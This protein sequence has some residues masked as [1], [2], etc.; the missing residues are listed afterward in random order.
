MTLKSTIYKLSLLSGLIATAAQ[1]NQHF[2]IQLNANNFSVQNKNVLSSSFLKFKSV[3]TDLDRTLGAPELPVKTWLVSGKPE[4]IKVQLKTH[5]QLNYQG[6]PY[7]VQP[8]D[9]RC[10]IPSK[11]AQ[12]FQFKNELYEKQQNTV[13]VHYL[14]AFRGQ[15]ISQVVVRLGK[16]NSATQET[17]I[18]TSAEVT[19]NTHEFQM[20][21][22][23]YKNFLI[24]T[25]AQLTEGLN[26]FI[27]WKTSQGYNVAVETVSSPNNTTTAIQALIKKYYTDKKADFVMIVGDENTIPMFKVSTSGSSQTPSD[28]KYFTMDGAQDNVPDIFASRLVADSPA[29][30]TAQL[31]K[32]IEFEKL[33][34]ENLAAGNTMAHKFIGIASNEGS[35]PSDEQYVRSIEDQFKAVLKSEIVHLAQNDKTNS[36]PDNLNSQFNSGAFWLTYVGHGS[37]T[38]WPSMAQAYSTSHIKQIKNKDA[39]KPIIIDV[40]C[41]NGRLINS[42]LGSQFMRV[43]AL[44]SNLAFGAVAYYG[45]SVNISWNPPAVMAQGIAFEHLSKKFNH[46]G[47]ALLAGQLYLAS[48]WTSTNEV[49]DNYEWYHLQGDPSLN[50]KF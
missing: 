19:T 16:Y 31:A 22:N 39:M 33:N 38:S 14:G 11:Q 24:V 26:D 43:D 21:Q 44:S 32:S 15:D 17:Q 36:K 3:A 27:Q 9:C 47:E 20:T 18:T 10:D 45:G 5:Q 6:K 49:V 28:L 4:Q 37:G 8:E 40:A 2:Q 1:A 23:E 46:L 12:T 7:P 30:V 25:T 42:Y 13:E 48:K 35:N 50:I 41:Q 29:Q 34:Q